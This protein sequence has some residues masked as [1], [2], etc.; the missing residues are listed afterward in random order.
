MDTQQVLDLFLELRRSVEKI[1]DDVSEIHGLVSGLD[2]DRANTDRRIDE[3]SKNLAAFREE[4]KE[5]F[6]NYS[7]EHQQ[8]IT[9]RDSEMEAALGELKQRVG[10]LEKDNEDLSFVRAMA[11]D[12]RGWFGK[13][14]AGSLILMI[15]FGIVLI[16]VGYFGLD[17]SK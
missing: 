2:R 13:A 10:V 1:S 17:F 4:I 8:A 11:N 3:L 15:V 14:V 6:D 5:D 12:A 16:G 7:E 9:Q